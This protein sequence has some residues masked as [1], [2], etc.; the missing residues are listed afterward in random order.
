[1]AEN[2]F[3]YFIMVLWNVLRSMTKNY[4]YFKTNSFSL[5]SKTSIPHVIVETSRTLSILAKHLKNVP[6][7]LMMPL[8]IEGLSYVWSHIEHFV[9]TVRNY[10]K[11]FFVELV[12]VAAL[13]KSTGNLDN[14]LD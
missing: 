3:V 1:M 13:H 14:F 5:C 9:D 4:L 8:F 10:A 7:D 6:T 12:T 2:S 11:L